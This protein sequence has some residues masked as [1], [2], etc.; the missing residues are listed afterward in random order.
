MINSNGYVAVQVLVDQ[1]GSVYNNSLTISDMLELIDSPTYTCSILSSQNNATTL[2]GYSTINI[3]LSGII[4][5]APQN[6]K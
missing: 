1:K 6:F 2:T 5:T 3:D 4:I